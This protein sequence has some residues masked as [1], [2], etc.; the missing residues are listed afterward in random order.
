MFVAFDVGETLIQYAGV[1]L[2]WTTHYRPALRHALGR[3]AIEA[4]EDSLAAAVDILTAY[5]TRKH[6][7]LHEIRAGEA[8]DRIA[9]LF[10]LPTAEFG[11]GF[12]S[13]FQRR[14]CPMPGAARLLDGLRNAGVYLAAFS[15]VPYGMPN[16]LLIE[17]LGELAG[18]FHRIA[19]SCDVGWRKPD[20]RGLRQL[21]QA[22]GRTSGRA[23]YVGNER[24]DID[25]A[26]SA[27]MQS[28]LLAPGHAVPAFGQRYTVA[29]LAEVA[30]IVLSS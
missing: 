12:F 25:A 17:D 20:G 15:D 30:D 21:L 7:R 11:C 23:F 9:R 29:A 1:A 13:Y 2:D 3:F 8:T 22:S 18:M 28:I 6:P 14:A 4:D 24:K 16:E 26:H 19:S 27:G 5:N 10:A